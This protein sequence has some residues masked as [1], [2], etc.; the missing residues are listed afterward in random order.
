MLKVTMRRL[1]LG[2]VAMS[3]KI[4][5]IIKR[6][7]KRTIIWPTKNPSPGAKALKDIDKLSRNR[8]IVI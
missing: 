1:A 8:K 5:S 4:D 3:T 7:R 6:T 2:E